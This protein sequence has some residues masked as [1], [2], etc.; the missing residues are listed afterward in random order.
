MQEESPNIVHLTVSDKMLLRFYEKD[1][2]EWNNDYPTVKNPQALMKGLEKM[3]RKMCGGEMPAGVVIYVMEEATNPEHD[4]NNVQYIILIQDYSIT[5]PGHDKAYSIS[6]LYQP[7]QQT[8]SFSWVDENEITWS[9][10]NLNNSEHPNRTKFYMGFTYMICEN[11]PGFD[12]EPEPEYELSGT[13]LLEMGF[14]GELPP[15]TIEIS[16]PETETAT[17]KELETE[18]EQTGIEHEEF[19]ETMFAEENE[20][21]VLH[22]S[23]NISLEELPNEQ[24]NEVEEEYNDLMVEFEDLFE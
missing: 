9:A 5:H 18:S 21:N 22:G 12:V 13:E 16:I 20:D 4:V 6:L 8:E 23:G 11:S 3:C 17:E 10:D 2:I 15:E 14:V 19:F 24:L 1:S 7:T